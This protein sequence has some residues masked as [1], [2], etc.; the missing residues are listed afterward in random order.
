MLSRH[1][2]IIDTNL[3]VSFLLTKRFNFV[4][5]LLD[6]VARPKLKP[7]F[8]PQ[9]LDSLLQLIEESALF[10]EVE[11]TVSVCRDEKDNFLLALA[12]ESQADYLLTGD[13]DLLVLKKFE[14]TS[15]ITI[16]AYKDVIKLM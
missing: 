8:A 1:K 15:I 2:V 7:F 5:E 11:T 13:K 9:L 14:Q 3:W 4:D 12:K 10:Y 16:A 6:V